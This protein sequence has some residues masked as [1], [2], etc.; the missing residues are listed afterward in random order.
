MASFLNIMVVIQSSPSYDDLPPEQRG[1]GLYHYDEKPKPRRII[2]KDTTKLQEEEQPQAAADDRIEKIIADNE[3]FI[4][5][6]DFALSE[7][8]K[9]MEGVFL[10]VDKDKSPEVYASLTRLF[11]E[12]HDGKITYAMYKQLVEYTFEYGRAKLLE[13]I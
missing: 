8:D 1:L 2:S 7:I 5:G 12:G 4:A 3:R 10:V 11:G 13:E 9:R 6:V